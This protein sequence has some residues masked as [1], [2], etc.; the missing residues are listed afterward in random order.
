MIRVRKADGSAIEIQEAGTFVELV[1][2]LDQTVMLSLLQLQPGVL[3]QIRPG[4]VDAQRYEGMFKA[5]GVKFS[6]TM[7]VRGS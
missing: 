5:Q 4:T 2:D 3:L 6:E 1:N 7:I